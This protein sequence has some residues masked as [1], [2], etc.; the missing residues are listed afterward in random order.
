MIDH[1]NKVIHVNISGTGSEGIEVLFKG[2][3]YWYIHQGSTWLCSEQSKIAYQQ[4]HAGGEDYWD[5]CFKMSMVRNP[6][7]RVLSNLT[8]H[9]IAERTSQ[10]GLNEYDN[11][12]QLLDFRWYLSSKYTKTYGVIVEQWTSFVWMPIYGHIA[13]YSTNIVPSYDHIIEKGYKEH[14]IYG[15]ILIEPLDALFHAENYEEAIHFLANKYEIPD[16]RVENALRFKPT[17]HISIP[18]HELPE[19]LRSSD[20]F[21]TFTVDDLRPDDI[22]MIND[23]YRDDFVKYGYEMIDP[24]TVK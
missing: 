3:E 23:L 19:R 8:A 10:I 15:N 6:Y 20:Q 21:T 18:T 17:S 2:C 9:K 5:S 22:T 7:E 16:D 24:S 13:Q 12:D 1:T 14:S 4:A 11:I